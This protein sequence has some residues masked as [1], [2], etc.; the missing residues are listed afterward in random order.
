MDRTIM[1][2]PIPNF[3]RLCIAALLK[4]GSMAEMQFYHREIR[5]LR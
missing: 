4:R 5:N 3:V 1:P 2:M